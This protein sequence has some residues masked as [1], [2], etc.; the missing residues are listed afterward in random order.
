MKRL[1]WLIWRNNG[2]F[3]C[4]I[5]GPRLHE[6]CSD[7][8]RAT[9]VVSSIRSR[10]A[11]RRRWAFFV[12]TLWGVAFRAVCFVTLLAKGL[13]FTARR[14]AHPV[15]ESRAAASDKAIGGS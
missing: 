5:R 2:T 15:P 7:A 3:D 1:T 6:K 10:G 8:R 4:F 13:P 12:Q 9:K 11:Q 14:F